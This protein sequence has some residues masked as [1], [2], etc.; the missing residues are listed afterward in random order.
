MLLTR[1]FDEDVGPLFG[2]GLVG[3]RVGGQMR[4]RGTPTWTVACY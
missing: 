4:D 2:G 1:V 3:E